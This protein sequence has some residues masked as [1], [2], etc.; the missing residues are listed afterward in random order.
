MGQEERR[1]AEVKRKASR[2]YYA[3]II[4]HSRNIG[5]KV[6]KEL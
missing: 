6:Q 2:T 3:R 4:F 1:P 5:Q